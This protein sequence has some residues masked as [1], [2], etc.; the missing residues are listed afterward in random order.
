ME[1]RNDPKSHFAA[2]TAGHQMTVLLDQGLYRHLRFATPG[3]SIGWYELI[4]TPNLL[5][6][7]GDMGTF[8]FSR[9]EDMLRFFERPDG[10]INPGYWAEKIHAS[11]GPAA[12]YSAKVFTDTVRD[13]A[14]DQLDGVDEALHGQAL[15]VLEEEVLNYAAEGEEEAR[16]ALDRFSHD[17]LE[18]TDTWE[19]NFT[20]HS[21]RYL[22]N[23]HAIVRGITRYRALAGQ[24]LE[25][26]AE[27]A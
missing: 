24:S 18:L 13:A 12:V 22:W 8:M 16:S 10:S 14:I 20:N 1:T 27:A 26:A 3:N 21:F 19:Y 9:M 6:I 4:T 23:L 7:N 15:S 5:T 17:L 11:S 25:E 2:D